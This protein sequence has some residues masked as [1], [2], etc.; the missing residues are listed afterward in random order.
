MSVGSSELQDK[1][2]HKRTQPGCETRWLDYRYSSKFPSLC[3]PYLS[4]FKPPSLCLSLWWA[5]HL[6]FLCAPKKCHYKCMLCAQALFEPS[7]VCFPVKI[8]KMPNS[9]WHAELRGDE[10]IAGTKMW[11]TS[12]I[13][14]VDVV[15][16][17]YKTTWFKY[18][19]RSITTTLP[20][21]IY[22]K[23]FQRKELLIVFIPL[24]ESHVFICC[25]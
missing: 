2:M 13:F 20:F 16:Q 12:G 3:C 22:L 24:N 23:C 10:I 15:V 21:D 7:D 11:K 4:V 5:A 8:S 18:F 17:P 14:P 6:L 9:L 25:C 1:H 19:N